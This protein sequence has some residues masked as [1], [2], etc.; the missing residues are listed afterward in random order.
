MT[1][2]L[3]HTGKGTLESKPIRSNRILPSELFEA[4][5]YP[6]FEILTNHVTNLKPTVDKSPCQNNQH[7]SPERLTKTRHTITHLSL[8]PGTRLS[9]ISLLLQ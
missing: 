1:T 7:G 5:R 3:A 6:A 4:L 2:A 8:L 9:I